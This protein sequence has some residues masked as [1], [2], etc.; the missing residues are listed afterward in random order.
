MNISPFINFRLFQISWILQ[1]VVLQVATSLAGQVIEQGNVIRVTDMAKEWR[2]SRCSMTAHKA[3]ENMM[4]VSN[5][6]SSKTNYV[7]E[8]RILISTFRSKWAKRSDWWSEIL[9][10]STTCI[11][12]AS[13]VGMCAW[14]RLRRLRWRC[15]LSL[16]NLYCLNDTSSLSPQFFQ[17][18][19][20]VGA[21][22]QT[23]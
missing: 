15:W 3:C 11:P 18:N 7:Q 2:A 22:L 5:K 17:H 8:K 4:K 20:H 13:P 1:S 9:K 21:I 19:R 10:N 16:T 14:W 12:F 23:G 6:D